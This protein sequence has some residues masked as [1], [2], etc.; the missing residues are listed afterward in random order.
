MRERVG[1]VG[2]LLNLSGCLLMAGAVLP[3]DFSVAQA[4]EKS[5]GV[6]QLDFAN[7][8]TTSQ[9]VWLAIIFFVLYL[10]LKRW[11]LPQMAEVLQTR[12]ETIRH[13][14]DVAQQAKGK[15]DTAA[16]SATQAARE[17]HAAAQAEINTALD[18]AKQA[19]AAEAAKLNA[20]L[21][22]DLAAAETRIAEAR[23]AAMG[24]LH[25]VAAETTATV[26]ARLTGRSAEAGRIDAAV[27][28]AIAASG[29]MGR[30]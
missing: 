29:A 21:E 14:L 22:A 30:S 28:T 24:A 7:P 8:L 5:V 12:A 23:T 16:A 2:R 15:A 25:A 1:A 4:A 3:G 11:A 9:V 19:A 10:L 18:A 17:A 6:P 13:D 27:D 26:V 20:K